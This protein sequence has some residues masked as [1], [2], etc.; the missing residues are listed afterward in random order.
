MGIFEE[1]CLGAAE[2]ACPIDDI[3][4]A[5]Q[6]QQRRCLDEDHPQVR[7]ARQRIGPHLW[8]M[9]APEGLAIVHAIG[10]RGLK[11][12]TG[13]GFEG[14]INRVGSE[15]AKDQRKGDDCEDKAPGFMHPLR[16]IAKRHLG[17]R[18]H[19]EI[20]AAVNRLRHFRAKRL[21]SQ[22]FD[23]L[24]HCD[25]H[26]QEENDIGNAAN[27]RGVDVPDEPQ[28]QETGSPGQC[29]PETEKHDH[30]CRDKNQRENNDETEI[31]LEM[32]GCRQIAGHPLKAFK[33]FWV[34]A[35]F[36]HHVTLK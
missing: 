36:H 11:L 28:R 17:S 15:S 34:G 29:P 8:Q 32:L 27:H 20:I 16:G 30:R 1:C 6:E 13:N 4:D 22:I 26:E 33:R 12:G 18:T 31:E 25:G 21:V 23:T 3:L 5:E 9:D 35:K 2:F 19:H 7:K 10:A 14:A 24:I